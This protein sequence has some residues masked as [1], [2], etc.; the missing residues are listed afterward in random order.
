MVAEEAPSPVADLPF[1]DVVD[2]NVVNV[3]VVVTDKKG[4]PVSGLEVDDFELLVDRKPRQ[5]SNFYAVVGGR[6][7]GEE[8]AAEGSPEPIRRGLP[9]AEGPVDQQLH[10]IVYIDNLNLRPF[11]RNRVMAAIRTFLRTRLGPGDEAML[12]SYERALHVRVPFTHDA[13]LVV[14]GLFDLEE[15]TA[16]GVH[17]DTERREIL[18]AIFEAEQLSEVHGQANSYAGSLHNDMSFTLSALKEYVESLAGLPG[19]KAILYVSDGLSMRPAEDV[20]HALNQ[21]FQ[22][23]SVLSEIYRWDLSRRFQEL[24]AA[25]NAHRVTF[26]TFDAAGLRTYSNIDASQSN[27]GL[28]SLVEQVYISNLQT[29]L[30]MMAE[31]TGGTAVINT[32]G[33][34]APLD[35]IAGDLG[36]Y[37]SLGFTTSGVGGRYYPIEVKVKGD[38]GLRVRHREG[39]RDKPVD[40]RMSE[41]TLAALQYGFQQ[42]EAGLDLEIGASKPQG[43]GR[44]FEVSVVIKIPLGRLVYIP[45]ASHQRGRVRLYIAARDG[46]GG[47][48]PVQDVVVP[49]DIPTAELEQAKQQIWAYQ[50]TLSMRQGRQMIAVGLR[51][52]I[53]GETAIVTRGVAVGG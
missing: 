14:S 49:I 17:A 5:I 50:V 6:A 3:E 48:A 47:L 31:A 4:N 34:S 27:P 32:N 23:S 9:V 39:F 43:A 46:E 25:A 21:K 8:G 26:Y 16:Q 40:T 30:Q 20:Y 33:F 19:R 18:D 52:E 35:R 37:Y 7:V 22:E 29:P 44:L 2:V 12:V 11:N 38:K 41:S 13:E 53:G 45:D 28:G 10:L 51:D 15:V 1:V 24:T 42:N 36:N